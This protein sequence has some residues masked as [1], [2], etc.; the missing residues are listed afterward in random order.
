MEEGREKKEILP[1]SSPNAKSLTQLYLTMPNTACFPS[2][3]FPYPSS[4][5]LFHRLL[6]NRS[7]TSPRDVPISSQARNSLRR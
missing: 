3:L 5:F 1:A 4:L 2:S 6:V 7:H